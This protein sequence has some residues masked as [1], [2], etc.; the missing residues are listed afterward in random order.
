[1]PGY[2][3]SRV[4]GAAQTSAN[5]LFMRGFLAEGKTYPDGLRIRLD[6]Y[7]GYFAEI[8][9]ALERVEVLRGPASVLYC[10]ASGGLV[11]S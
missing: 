2:I 7:F 8:S 10:Q 5:N 3:G 9:F 11:V 4:W 1:M 6:S